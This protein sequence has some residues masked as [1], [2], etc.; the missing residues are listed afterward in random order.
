MAR[1]DGTPGAAPLTHGLLVAGNKI[2]SG[3]VASAF[4]VNDTLYNVSIDPDVLKKLGDNIVIQVLVKSPAIVSYR[5]GLAG[6][7]SL[8]AQ[9]FY[10]PIWIG[11]D[12][13]CGQWQ[14]SDRTAILEYMLILRKRPASETV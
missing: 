14:I 5:G 1:N 4:A 3:A 2:N 10:Q 7:A 6:I 9:T 11:K 8:A 13:A 12:G